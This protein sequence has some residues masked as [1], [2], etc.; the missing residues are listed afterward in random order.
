MSRDSY[1]SLAISLQLN[2]GENNRYDDT[3]LLIDTGLTCSVMKNENML[4]NVRKSENPL[5]AYTNGGHQDSNKEGDFLGFFKVWFN[6]K[7]RV[8]ILSFKD[9]RKIFRATAFQI[10]CGT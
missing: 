1:D 5:R 10:G 9:V 4:I 7:C 8:N 3:K 6:P 2:Q